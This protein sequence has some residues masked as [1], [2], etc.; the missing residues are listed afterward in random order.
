MKPEHSGDSLR[1]KVAEWCSILGGIA[2]LFALIQRYASAN[3][4]IQLIDDAWPIKWALIII[5]AY[6][7]VNAAIPA[8]WAPLK[9][10]TGRLR[11]F[12]SRGIPVPSRRAVILAATAFLIAASL[13][14]SLLVLREA[15]SIVDSFSDDGGYVNAREQ[16]ALETLVNTWFP[17]RER[18]IR[19]LFSGVNLHSVLAHE[20]YLVQPLA[21]IARQRRGLDRAIHTACDSEL[22]VDADQLLGCG[23]L[24]TS[25]RVAPHRAIAKQFFLSRRFQ[26]GRELADLVAPD[27]RLPVFFDVL[28]E[29]GRN[30]FVDATSVC[31]LVAIM[32]QASL[33]LARDEALSTLAK[34]GLPRPWE[35]LLA[36]LPQSNVGIDVR[37][38]AETLKREIGEGAHLDQ[39]ASATRA[40]AILGTENLDPSTIDGA[41]AILL[42]KTSNADSTVA[43]MDYLEAL[44]E[45]APYLSGIQVD[46]IMGALNRSVVSARSGL[47][48]RRAGRITAAFERPA[49]GLL[50][51]LITELQR[52]SAHSATSAETVAYA[53]VVGDLAR[54]MGRQD[55]CRTSGILLAKI[56]SLNKA[57]FSRV[58]RALALIDADVECVDS[59]RVLVVWQKLLEAGND[60]VLSGERLD[61]AFAFW[62]R[63]LS[64]PVQQRLAV[65]LLE[66]MKRESRR[67][68]VSLAAFVNLDQELRSSR[69]AADMDAIVEWLDSKPSV[70]HA[71]AIAQ[72]LPRLGPYL[73]REKKRLVA[74]YIIE[75]LRSNNDEPV[76]LRLSQ[77]APDDNTDLLVTWRALFEA[78]LRG[79]AP[80]A[81]WQF[82]L[83]LVALG[84]RLP[85]YEADQS[86]QQLL[87]RRPR[88]AGECWIATSLARP[89]TIAAL[90][91]QV[92]KWATCSSAEYR[93]LHGV[94]SWFGIEIND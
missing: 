50:R 73:S 63:R 13:I 59:D 85:E 29:V 81:S 62:R 30:D 86:L 26:H 68:D 71:T 15:Q 47:D 61:R 52:R 4:I 8:A 32:P 48:I 56:Q 93:W 1:T 54:F 28:R 14:G 89:S 36:C 20:A 88:A 2:V 43:Q 78:W 16:Q 23:L 27:D 41:V 76:A 60:G 17:V 10:L 67:P 74:G 46:T 69:S 72:L 75:S 58:E 12:L 11:R 82:A 65:E 45:L 53:E 33:R 3:E 21:R 37:V 70:R 64:A 91:T 19:S 84:A 79:L 38:E 51:D 42:A 6:W 83:D 90:E 31:E 39:I 92:A 22:R 80:R 40:L 57:D 77:L 25:A 5:A 18:A 44:G 55:R 34:T 94:L 66:S 49:R 9:P 24:L 7:I 87:K 35:A